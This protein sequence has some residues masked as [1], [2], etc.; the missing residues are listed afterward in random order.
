[1]KVHA[2]RRSR[3]TTA[4][5]AALM[6]P[7]AA[8]VAQD[9][10]QD[11]QDARTLDRVTV[12]GS[13]IPQAQ[14]ETFTPVTVITAEDIQARGFASVADILQQSAF[15]TGGV[16]GSQS[17]ASFT[18]GAETISLFGLPPGYVKYLIDGRPMANYP[19][20]YN[21]SDT[22]NN[23]SGIPVD[24][25][26]RIEILPGGQSSL[27][28]SDAIAGVINVI[29]KKEM[30]GSALNIRGG[31]YSEGGGNSFRA[32]FA[33]GFQSADGR[34]N[35]LLGIQ[36]EDRDAI[37]GYDREL[38]SQ[39]NTNGTSAPL[40]SRDYLVVSPFNSYRFL[41]P[42]NC[43]NVTGQFGGTVGLQRR[44]GFGDEYYCGSFSTP[45]YRTLRN[46]KEATQVYGNL[47]FEI[48]DSTQLYANVL[49]SDEKVG[50][51]VGSNYTWWGSNTESMGYYFYDPDLDDLVS[52]QRAFA[53]EDM[54]PGGFDNSMQFDES[55][56][57]RVS[58]GV[59]G[60]LGDS[61]W[62]YDVGFTR[63]D[64]ELD[65]VG[66]VR[67]AG[68]MDAYFRD[69]VLGPQLGLDPLYGAYPVYSPDYAAF[70]QP[71]SPDDFARLTG[72]A[73]SQSKTVDQMLRFQITNAQ[74]FGLPGGDAGLAV[75]AEAGS[76]EWR[77]DPDPGYLDGTIW[78]T[79]AVSG[80]GERDRYA[81]TT[82]LRMPV[83][84]PL[85]VTLSGRYDAFKPDGGSTIDKPT[86][87]LGL[88]YRPIDELLVRGKY[89][90]AFRSPTLSDLYQGE[91]G[92]YTFVTDYYRCNQLGF[93][94]GNT[95]Q[96]PAALSNRQ[97]FGTQ[98]G[99]L[100]LQPINA[101]VWSLGV[102][103]SP[104]AR[105]SLN[106]DY[107]N[108]DISD[109]V[110]Q[111][112]SNNLMLQEYRCRT[113]IDDINSQLCT[114]TLSQITRNPATNLVTEIY[115]PKINVSRQTLEAITAGLNYTMDV[116]IGSLSFRGNYT[117]KLDH[118]YQQ[119]AEDP[120]IDL[121]N[122]PYWS[123]DPKRKADASVTWSTDRWATTL[124]AN[125]FSQTP[126]YRAEVVG[127][128]D[129]PLSRKL[130]S[131]LV[132]NA[133]VSFSP[134]DELQFSL[135]VNN[136]FNKMPPMDWSYPGT[137]GAPYNSNNFNVYGRAVYLEARYLF[138]QR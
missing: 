56:S 117:Q 75:V 19:A 131:H 125:W 54:G 114:A 76:Q 119:Y 122:D 116:G 107:H 11:S 137:S 95:S 97:V 38:T 5:L 46:S 81:L 110:T 52:L 3:L 106:V 26:D 135:L 134:I 118:Q 130:P 20:L 105:M 127:N 51:H 59:N 136:L 128:Y 22:F 32:S 99:S 13:L 120:N 93:E 108:W 2:A 44:P 45:G 15:S 89:G 43:A 30:N 61:T 69:R 7:S 94:P 36:Y 18:Q 63:T 65:E 72:Y 28:G 102:V 24:L 74:L 70:Y 87:S 62:D 48:N 68:P 41:D 34:T 29:L 90:T 77:Y 88:E 57:T 37:W 71:M 84:E 31:T 138:G 39:F 49:H 6:I 17:S 124:Y 14:I 8:V 9:G 10:T 91:S 115:T 53:P 33:T 79:T 121:L 111:Q 64:Y 113:G 80:G 42:N 133:T 25:I 101:D 96:C 129:D 60:V 109:E 50:Y 21:G 92:Y 85:T 103:W 86:Y 112:S 67:W 100:D 132:Y 4:L 82:E 58:L 104:I 12:T 1:M 23:I 126:N 35:A 83:L 98:E 78:G 123:A 73:T 16:Q 40:A 27:Y 47:T 66:F 55:K